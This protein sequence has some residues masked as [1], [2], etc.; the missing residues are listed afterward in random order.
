MASQMTAVR[1]VEKEKEAGFCE[2]DNDDI[3]H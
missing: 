1:Y 3:E 2:F